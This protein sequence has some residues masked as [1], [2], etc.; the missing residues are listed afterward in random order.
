[1]GSSISE[2]IRVEFFFT[3]KTVA[4]DVAVIEIAEH[5]GEFHTGR[6]EVTKLNQVQLAIAIKVR[7]FEF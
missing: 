4:V 3:E 7:K 2:A 5:V 1:M 6:D